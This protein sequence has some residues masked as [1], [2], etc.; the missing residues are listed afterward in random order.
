MSDTDLMVNDPELSLVQAAERTGLSR[1]TMQRLA[2]DGKIIGAVKRG[3]AWRIPQSGLIAAGLTIL[4]TPVPSSR[5]QRDLEH[6]RAIADAQAEAERWRVRAENLESELK[7]A[8]EALADLRAVLQ[9]QI[10]MLNAAPSAQLVSEPM[11]V[12][13]QTVEMKQPSRSG[14]RRLWRSRSR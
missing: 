13:N 12:G 10:L 6:R 2:A 4:E 1:A 7:R 14:L 9:S 11:I 5:E 3:R 8:D